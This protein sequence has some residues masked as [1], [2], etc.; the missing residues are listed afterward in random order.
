MLDTTHKTLEITFNES[1]WP[2]QYWTNGSNIAA[3]RF[4]DNGAKQMLGVIGSNVLPVSNFTQQLPTTRNNM[5]QGTV[6]KDARL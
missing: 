5:H 3:L 6:Q 4:G 1:A 2:K